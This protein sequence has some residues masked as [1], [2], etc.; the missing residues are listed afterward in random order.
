MKKNAA[1][2]SQESSQ[3]AL[4]GMQD[5]ERG[6]QH[7]SVYG[8]TRGREHR[9]NAVLRTSSSIWGDSIYFDYNA[10]TP[11]DPSVREA[12]MPFLDQE[13]G[14]HYSFYSLGRRAATAVT[15]ARERVAQLLNATSS[16]IIFTSCA[17]ESIVTAFLSALEAAPDKRHLITSTVEHSATLELCRYYESR[18]YEITYLPVDR[19]GNLSLEQLKQSITPST[20]LISLLWANNETGVIF[21]VEKVAAI[22]VEQGVPLHLDAVQAVG[23]IPIDLQALPVSYLSLSGHKIYAPK[24]IGALYVHRHASYTPL[25]CG[26]QEGTRRGG[27]ENVANIVGFGH[28]AMIAAEKL[29]SEWPRLTALRDRFETNLF[30]QLSGVHRNGNLFS[31]LPNTS[32]LTFDGIEAASAL[33]LFDRKSLC[34]SAGSACNTQSR[35]PSHVLSAMGRSLEEAAATVRFSFGRFTTEV[36]IDQA[37]EIISGVVEKLRQL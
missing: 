8:H 24:G 10:T 4:L 32:S 18:G 35:S 22:A 14:N 25:L 12:M 16:E 19:D 20:A 2:A 29:S 33:F 3:N 21:P 17:T 13:F 11:I 26:S 23:K 7:R 1:I 27:T 15:E 37:L 5:K 30:Q 28:A 6:A 36:E 34:C 9:S 31:R